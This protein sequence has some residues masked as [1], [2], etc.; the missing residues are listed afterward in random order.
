MQDRCNG[1]SPAGGAFDGL[2]TFFATPLAFVLLGY[3]QYTASS[4]IILSVLVWLAYRFAGRKIRPWSSFDSS[5]DRRN[6]ELWK[7][8]KY[9]VA[10]F[11][12][13]GSIFTLR[14]KRCWVF[15]ADYS[16]LRR[17]IKL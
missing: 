10:G 14:R 12:L 6:D 17:Q 5:L 4:W 11:V 1:A 16:V 13:F 9:S 7:W 3:R 8:F 2:L 15:D